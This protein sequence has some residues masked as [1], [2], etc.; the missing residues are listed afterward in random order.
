MRQVDAVSSLH[1]CQQWGWIACCWS[2]SW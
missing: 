1:L 2:S